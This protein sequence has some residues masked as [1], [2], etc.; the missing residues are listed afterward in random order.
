M[1]VKREGSTSVEL[2]DYVRIIRKQWLLISLVVGLAL[3]GGAAV[4]LAATPQYA[5]HVT[6]FV[7]TSGTGGTGGV[8]DAYQGSLFSQQRVKSYV[9]LLSSERLAK[10]IVAA[11]GLELS[12]AEVA[13]KISATAVPDTVLLDATV[14]DSSPE[15]ARR[16]A[17]AMSTEFI[18]LVRTLETPP[19]RDTAAVKVEV[20]EGPSVGSSPVSPAPVKNIVMA[21]L[22]G[23]V[24][25]VGAAVLREA[26]DTTIKTSEDVLEV[27]GVPTLAT[28]AFSGESKTAPL[29]VHDSAHAPRAE[30]FR[31]LRTN[32]RFVDVDRPLKVIVVTSAVP[33]EGKS[34]TTANLAITMAQAG[35]KVLLIE[36]DL[37]RPK[38]VEYLGLEGAIGLTNV[39][40]GQVDIDTVLQPWGRDGLWV[41]SSGSIPPNPSELLGSQNMV[42]LMQ[43]LRERFDVILVDAPPLLPVTDAA[44]AAGTADGVVL[45]VRH[46]HVTRAQVKTAAETLRGVDAHLVGAVLNM[47]PA[48]GGDA[49]AYEYSYDDRPG[50]RERLDEARHVPGAARQGRRA[51]SIDQP[52][53]EV[54]PRR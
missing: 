51:A 44:V 23:V 26:L 21:L 38:V 1:S 27:V 34:T 6:F 10:D 53:G 16:V 4:T 9:D 37:R 19:G 22:L 33:S 50:A 24:L 43:H 35:H 45:V 25:G 2:R 11:S 48:K 46:G 39:L 12:P 18:D 28:V 20:I 47:A 3:A 42:E 29:V 13:S 30:A 31:Q 7:T 54:S 41:L 14:T 32:L 17:S 15:Q 52:T 40:V 5:A 36:G 8:A 49:Y